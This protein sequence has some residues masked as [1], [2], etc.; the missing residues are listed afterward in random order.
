MDYNATT[1]VD[2][3]V[4][5]AMLPLLKDR[6]GNPSSGHLF[7]K[8][9]KEEL[10]KAR[11]RVA[12]LISAKPEEVV[13]T[14]GGTESDNQAIMGTALRKGG[15]VITSTI[16]H[17]AVLETCRYLEREFGQR[18]TYV[19][20]DRNGL[21]NP[22]DVEEAI[23]KD[24]CLISIMHANNEVGTLEPLEEIGRIAAEHDVA[25]HTDAAQSCGK[26]VV[27]VDRLGVNLLTMAGHKLYAPK[28][29]GALYVRKG[30]KVDGLLHGAGQ[31]NGRRAGTEN[32]PYIVGLG[33]AC[34]LARKSQ[35]RFERG[36]RDL[37]DSLH[38]NISEGLGASRVIL[39]GH[40]TQR[41]PNTLNISIVG[42]V[43]EDLLRHM[44]GLA[45]STGS[46][47]HS[48]S[49]EPSPVLLAM[50][51]RR[52]L[53]RGALR[54]SLGRWTSKEEVQRASEMIVNA[55]ARVRAKGTGR[56]PNEGL[57]PGAGPE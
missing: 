9:A 2:P 23:T 39:N 19:P 35:R 51:I 38:R 40:P 11:G 12:S 15:H 5:E 22:R 49:V 4:L 21:V 37:R 27:D 30:F 10:E 6:F 18:V 46:A 45:A 44:P 55:A 56:I 24:T 41:L 14:S 36:V 32:V 34:D 7:G 13:F 33:V 31:E 47:C 26:V 48:G 29:V 52:E 50:G 43:G 54:L 8:E 42:V 1:P 3:T 53:A 20:V 17:P 25:F 28:G 57:L 16:E